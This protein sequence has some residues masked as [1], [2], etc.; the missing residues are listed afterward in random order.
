MAYTTTATPCADDTNNNNNNNSS[1]YQ[2]YQST[3]SSS[4]KVSMSSLEFSLDVTS[5]SSSRSSRSK[6]D[7]NNS[8]NCTN[9]DDDQ[10]TTNAVAAATKTTVR[11]SLIHLLKGYIGPGCLSLPW[12]VS[13]TG[14]GL[15]AVACVMLAAWSSYNCWTVVEL[16]RQMQRE[17]QQEQD[18]NDC[19]EDDMDDDCSDDDNDNSGSDNG[20]TGRTLNAQAQRVG[21]GRSS[22]LTEDGADGITCHQTGGI[23]PGASLTYPGVAGW[24]CG[25]YMHRFTT[26]CVCTQQLAICTVFLSFIGANLQ[27]VLTACAVPGTA[28]ADVSHAAVITMA[29][30]AVLAL[31]CLPNLKALAPVT[32]AGTI[33]LLIG[34]ALLGLVVAMEWNNPDNNSSMNSNLIST[35]PSVP[36]QWSQV[37]LALCAILYSYEG[38][39]LVSPCTKPNQQSN[40]RIP[41]QTSLFTNIPIY[42]IP[43]FAGVTD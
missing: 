32:A 27:A 39:N 22:A 42:T 18:N 37:P 5:S 31:S 13:Q 17:L 7:N 9:N 14:F 29:L 4:A 19:I 2:S 24:L 10:Q 26:A 8:S 38:I 16:K 25:S 33:M 43:K 21:G 15:G 3:A 34:L 20:E 40:R 30:P 6:S 41:T 12:A 28:L 23:M 35:A 1:N 11:Q 36:V